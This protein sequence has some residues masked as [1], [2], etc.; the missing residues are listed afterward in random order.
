MIVIG[1]SASRKLSWEIAKELNCKF[2]QP[3]V[4]SFPDGELYV[5]IPDDLSGEEVVIVQSTPPPQNENL[6]E[7]FLLLEAASEQGPKSLKAVV[8]YLAY[9]RQDKIFKKGEALSLKL[10]S[11]F[12]E[13]AGAEELVVVDIHE[14]ESL[15]YFSIPVKNVTAA[16]LLGRYFKGMGLKDPL[17]LGPDEKAAQ[18]ASRAAKELGA[19]FDSLEKE[20]ITPELV[21]TSSKELRV[22]DRD[23]VIIDDIISTGG[24]IAEAAK[25][26]KKEGAR[27]IFAAC[28]HPVL[29]G[30]ALEKMKAAGVE[31]VVGTN[32]IE[33]SHIF[34]SVAPVIV[35]GLRQSVLL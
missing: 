16:P 14:R 9:A 26:L 6:M 19:S 24:T 35:E 2:S 25:I 13:E 10:I 18:Q 5:R 22:K 21:V 20:R 31:G 11:S 7:L 12:I 28:T 23:A 1:G 29:S 4:K 34:V 33:N 8:P 27:R 30:N 17:F 15:S 32:T 3:E